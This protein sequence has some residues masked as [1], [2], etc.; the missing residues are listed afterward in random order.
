MRSTRH[1]HAPTSRRL[2]HMRP[3]S[4]RAYKLGSMYMT[5]TIL[6]RAPGPKA[7]PHTRA[8][9]HARTHAHTNTDTH[10]QKQLHTSV[11]QPKQLGVRT[12]ATSFDSPVSMDSSAAARPDSTTPSTGNFSPV[13]AHQHIWRTRAANALSTCSQTAAG[14]YVSRPLGRAVPQALLT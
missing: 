1:A 14:I 11:H 3:H 7:C 8:H 6:A 13:G 4:M 5:R 9:T 2:K 10:T 12:L